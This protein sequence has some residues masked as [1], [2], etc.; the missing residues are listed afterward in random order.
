MAC[1]PTGAS[2][3]ARRKSLPP[4]MLHNAP[5]APSPCQTYWR[6]RLRAEEVV[7]FN[8]GTSSLLMRSAADG[9]ARRMDNP[10]GNVSIVAKP[11]DLQMKPIDYTI[12]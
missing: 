4:V 3:K 9:N 6:L 10:I 12:H 2:T 1:Q 8:D 11:C 7:A 5:L